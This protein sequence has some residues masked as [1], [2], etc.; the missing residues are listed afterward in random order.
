MTRTASALGLVALA[1]LI[2]ATSAPPP[3]DA[4]PM[5]AAVTANVAPSAG[6]SVNPNPA[7]RNGA[8]TFTSTG[9]CPDAPCTYR[10]FH[11]DSTNGAQA[12]IEA[13]AA[14]PNTEATFTYTGG[15]GPR[16]IALRVTD[17]DGQTSEATQTFQLVEATA[18]PTPTA[19]AS[20]TPSATP[21]PNVAPSAGFSVNPNP[22]VRN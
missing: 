18:T 10:W 20:P 21:T 22:A 6:F 19:T 3:V 1:L 15:A 17:A 7:V 12:E 16:G 8:T 13:G 2:S 5:D 14:Q 4:A 11:W 9:S